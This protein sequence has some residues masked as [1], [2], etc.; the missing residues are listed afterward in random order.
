LGSWRYRVFVAIDVSVDPLELSRL[1][2][3]VLGASKDMADAWRTAKAPL[4]VPLAAFGNTTSAVAVHGAHQ[5]LV[6][7]ADV[8]IGR[9]VTVLEDDV[10]RLYRVAFA[11]EKAEQDARTNLNRASQ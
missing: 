7:D 9:Q 1:A 6:D 3:K 10:D 5:G 2:A 8:A 11:Y 4:A